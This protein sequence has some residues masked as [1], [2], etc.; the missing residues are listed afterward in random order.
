M[1]DTKNPIWALKG[2]AI[3]WVIASALLVPFLRGSYSYEAAAAELAIKSAA[4][5]QT[6]RQGKLV[7][8][9]VAQS[10]GIKGTETFSVSHNGRLILHKSLRSDYKDGDSMWLGFPHAG[11]RARSVHTFDGGLGDFISTNAKLASS[12]FVDFD[13]DGVADLIVA[14]NYGNAANIYDIY[15]LR[16]RAKKLATISTTRSNADFMDIDQDGRCEIIAR[17]QTFFGWK[18]S[19]ADSPMPLVILKMN[20]KR[21]GLATA[22]M[23]SQPPTQSRQQELLRAWSKACKL[24]LVANN[25][26]TE[27]EKSDQTTFILAPVVWGDILNLVYSGN[28]EMAFSL[29]DKF[30]SKSAN[31]SNL[32]NN[33]DCTEVRTSKEQFEKMFLQQL[34]YSPFLDEIKQLNRSDARIRSLTNT[35]RIPT[36]MIE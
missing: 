19:N 16:A 14:H 7:L 30:W 32:E 26:P 9:L 33:S 5:V 34:S 10:S 2:T 17:D 3:A 27:K 1:A 20:H 6:Y 29:L 18:T 15:R 12:P 28:S 21:F 35:S 25:P 36:P 23:R 8:K 13:G 22:L 31:A 4:T 11:K 24:P